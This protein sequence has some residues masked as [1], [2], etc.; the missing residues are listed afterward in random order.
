MAAFVLDASVAISWCFP[1]DLMNR[2]DGSDSPGHYAACRRFNP[3]RGHPLATLPGWPYRRQP[4][5]MAS[6]WEGDLATGMTGTVSA[7]LRV[8]DDPPGGDGMVRR[9]AGAEYGF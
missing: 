9:G 6:W 7:I 5:P 4:R 2:F 8:A 1:G 3:P